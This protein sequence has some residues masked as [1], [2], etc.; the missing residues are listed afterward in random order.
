MFHHHPSI[1][2]DY[3]I[4]IINLTIIKPLCLLCIVLLSYDLQRRLK[5]YSYTQK[6]NNIDCL[7]TNWRKLQL[8]FTESIYLGWKDSVFS[9]I[10]KF[11]LCRSHRTW[12]TNQPT[13]D[14]I[15]PLSFNHHNRLR[16][17]A[18]AYRKFGSTQKKRCQNNENIHR[19]FHI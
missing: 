9:F 10:I 14:S 18:Y 8:K 17:S 1:S 13:V 12:K 3:V 15:R 6:P 4:R 2:M 19:S 11:N 5:H 7:V 16:E